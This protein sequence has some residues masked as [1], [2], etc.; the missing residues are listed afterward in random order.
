MRRARVLLALA[1][2]VLAASAASALSPALAGA[3]VFGPIGLA[4]ES[5]IPGLLSDQQADYAHDAAISGNGRYVAFDGSY[6]GRTGVWRRDLATGAVEAV[7][8]EDPSEP[9]ISAPDASMPSISED[10]R[11]V[12]FTTTAALDPIDD[13]NPGPDVYV[14]DMEIPASQ[15]CEPGPETAEPCAYTLVS[16]QD[17]SNVGLKYE[18]T[19]KTSIEAEERD[20]GAVAAGRSAISADGR[21]VAFVTT[22]VSNLAGPGTPPMQVAVRELDTD[23]TELV[24]VADDPATGQPVPGAPVSGFV[25]PEE[26]GA[27]G[28]GKGG[29]APIFADAAAYEPSSS[30]GVGA[31]ISADGSTVA[32]L[33][34]NI[35]EQARMLS[36]EAPPASYTEPLWR[37]IGDGPSAPTRRITGGSDPSAPGC[38]ES[39]ETALPGSPV[40]GDPCQ[41]PFLGLQ[42]GLTT[43]TWD[44]G[45]G[46]PIPR[47]SADGYTVAF[48]ANVQLASAAGGFGNSSSNNDL[49]VV[50]MHE[51]PTRKQA[52]RQLTEMAGG[53]L[54]NLAEDGPVEDFGIAP[55]GGYVAFT[56]KRIEFPLGTPAY[57]S[58]P[59]GAAGMLELFDVDLGD[60]TLTRVTQGFEGGPS[61][62]PHREVSSSEDPY[63]RVDDGA[64]S[65]SYSNGGELLAFTSTASNLVYGDG[66]TPPLGSDRFDGSDAFTVARTIFSPQP[67]PQ[68]ITPTPAPPATVPKWRLGVTAST[69]PNGT[70]LL[71]VTVPGAGTLSA[72]AQSSVRVRHKRRGHLSTTVATRGVASVKKVS[73]A[74]EGALATL[75][76]TLAHA[77]SSL[78]QHA[79]GLEGTV[80]VTFA[81]AHHPT[82]RAS[83]RVTFLR[84]LKS[85]KKAKKASSRH[86]SSHVAGASGGA[87]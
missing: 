72:V 58:A 71:Y 33:G 12:S 9:A 35:P 69:R 29:A 86:A 70:V 81:A 32:W 7:A 31:S 20:Y 44:S 78:A 41:G 87:R 38:A 76:L 26:Y 6:G 83:V 47:L 82:L 74:A 48:L 64:L 15:P 50:D 24:S 53:D 59:Q 23:R 27:V 34:V 14:R 56:T 40:P 8:V 67:T 42:D 79:P 30:A 2:A 73:H 11:Y 17:G 39:G 19:G 57:V 18:P 54:A 49:Y 52:L 25:G 80:T 60:Q 46:D 77:Y 63:Q 5:A 4:S 13:T 66:N 36:G 43:G 10:G 62:H 22:A 75:T 1:L 61:E 3:D 45:N 16:A 68:S 21:K 65:P 84:T 51:G 28:S 85:K 37:R 55:D